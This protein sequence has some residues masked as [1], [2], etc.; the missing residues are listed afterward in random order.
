MLNQRI[1]AMARG[2]SIAKFQ[3]ISL[4]YGNV[5]K[6]GRGLK[7]QVSGMEFVAFFAR[8]IESG[9]RR[10]IGDWIIFIALEKRI[11]N[12]LERQDYDELI[13]YRLDIKE[14]EGVDGS[15]E[16][17]FSINDVFK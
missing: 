13:D 10:Q 11:L 7:F 17:Y 15:G 1:D 14:E 4:K 12:I 16:S 2:V 3:N 6:L 5:E 9:F 8:D